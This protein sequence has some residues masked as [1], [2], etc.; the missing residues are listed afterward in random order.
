MAEAS[1]VLCTYNRAHLLWRALECYSR[2][3][4]S[5]FELLILDDMSQDDTPELVRSWRDRLNIVYMPLTD[6]VPG[7][8][9]DAGAIINRGIRAA[10]GR[11]VYITHPEVMVAPEILGAFNDVLGRYPG[12]FVNARPYYLTMGMQD[13]IDT[14]PWQSD[15][16]A[17]RGLPDFYEREEPVF[18]ETMND[19]GMQ[20]ILNENTRPQYIEMQ[21]VLFSWVF[22]G[23]TRAGWKKL[24]G[25][26][27]Y[28][29]WGTVDID[30]MMRRRERR[31]RTINPRFMYV[32]HQNHDKPT[33][34]FEPTKRD[35]QKITLDIKAHYPSHKDFLEDMPD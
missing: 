19:P 17:L 24:G 20:F 10:R 25:L 34:A 33:G 22:G 35:F 5:D 6:K 30:F 12:D 29:S 27:E 16:Y 9:R 2:V 21:P 4:F 13:A 14:V 23:M 32:V 26:N 7:V 1:V 28:P 15:F 8:W 11:F 3:A 31:I 18:H